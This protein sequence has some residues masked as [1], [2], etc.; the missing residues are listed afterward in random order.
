MMR[1]GQRILPQYSSIEY[2]GWW[3]WAQVA[4]IA[5]LIGLAMF[6]GLFVTVG[7]TQALSLVGAPIAF[8]AA[9]CLW[10]LPDVHRDTNPPFYKLVMAY[11]GLMIA[12]PSY[13]AIAIPG[14]PWITLPRIFLG[15]LLVVMALQ[16]AQYADVRR[17]IHE[18]ITYDQLS[19]RFYVLY[20]ITAIIT[21]PLSPGPTE[22]LTYTINQEI[23]GLVP[24][25]GLAWVLHKDID[26]LPRIAMFVTLCCILTMVIAVVENIM[27]QPPWLGYIPSFLKI[28]SELL[29]VYT[30]AQARAGDP[31]YRIRSTFGIVLYYSQYLNLTLPLLTYYMIRMRGTARWVLMPLLAVLVLHTIWYC[32]A[33]TA[34]IGFLLAI[35]GTGGLVLL[36]N[37]VQRRAGDTFNALFQAVMLAAFLAVMVVAISNSHR[38]QMYTIGGDQH[39]A[40]NRTRDRQWDNTWEQLARNPVGVGLGN[41]PSFV[42]TAGSASAIVDS[43]YINTLVDVGILGF[44][45][46]FGFMLRS[47]WLGLSIYL[48]SRDEL[49]ELA[50]PLTLGLMGLV[51]TDY[52]ISY[53]DNNYLAMMFCVV[54]LLLHRR[55]QK[56]IDDEAL[57]AAAPQLGTPGTSVVRR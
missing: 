41:S 13:V 54:I 12:W 46:F 35:L 32:N 24:A 10:L 27:Q 16:V 5:L 57:R 53:T 44:I 31:R 6:T 28:D 52:V 47:I 55:Q 50:A 30:S 56:A 49:D 39:A 34:S 3:R 7:G 43:Q 42:G 20:W 45:G 48:R 37:L 36:R 51:I 1:R 4:T 19:V 22:T 23:L 33:R 8:M 38:A 14:L 9:L 15:M 11:T 25:L 2:R 18:T 40:S 21:I 29:S 17:R 26:R